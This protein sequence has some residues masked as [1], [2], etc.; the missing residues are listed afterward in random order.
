MNQE[1]YARL[2]SHVLSDVAERRADSGEYL[3]RGHRRSTVIN[4]EHRRVF[5]HG[6]HICYQNEQFHDSDSEYRL[7]MAFSAAEII[8]Q[9]RLGR[10]WGCNTKASVHVAQA[11]LDSECERLKRRFLRSGQR[12]HTPPIGGTPVTPAEPAVL[13]L[14]ETIRRQVRRYRTQHSNW[15]HDFEVLVA[16]F[17]ASYWRDP[18]W[19]HQVEERHLQWLSNFEKRQEFEWVE[20]MQ[21][22]AM[23][24]LYHGQR[25]HAQ[26]VTVYRKAI[27]IARKARMK[28]EF[29]QVLL[30]WLRTSV[31]VSLRKANALADPNYSLPR[32]TLN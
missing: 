16:S 5:V 30:A 18:E 19:F 32:T 1:F 13:R 14:A 31:K 9:A 6:D 17:R 26:A 28:E 27:L 10:S 8:E 4:G 3:T 15:Q 12:R 23:A 11:L 25:K 2:I 22:V 21:I 20:A 7:V 24:H 29:R